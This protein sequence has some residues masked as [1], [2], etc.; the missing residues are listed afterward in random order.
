[1]KDINLQ[2]AWIVRKYCEKKMKLIKLTL[3]FLQLHLICKNAFFAYIT[4]FS[5]EILTK[6]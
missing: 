1:L 4:C 6:Q 2:T 5:A 3:T